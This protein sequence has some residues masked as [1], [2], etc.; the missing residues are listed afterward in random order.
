MRLAYRWILPVISCIPVL[1]GVIGTHVASE[2]TDEGGSAMALVFFFFPI[3]FLLALIS[4]GIT[5]ARRE[6]WRKVDR[7]IGYAPL[8]LLLVSVLVTVLQVFLGF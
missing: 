3:S 8:C 5:R 1:V 4:A 7:V 6:V 2:A